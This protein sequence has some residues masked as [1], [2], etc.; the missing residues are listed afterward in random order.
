MPNEVIDHVHRMAHQEKANHSL[1]FQ[2]RNR[3]LLSDQDDEDNDESYS[4]SV[5]DEA[6]EYELLEPV[7]DGNDDHTET[8]GVDTLAELEPDMI[9]DGVPLP[10]THARLEQG[11]LGVEAPDDA[12]APPMGPDTTNPI[13]EPSLE[14]TA[15]PQVAPEVTA[16]PPLI[17]AP[18]PPG[19][20]WELCRLEINNEVPPLTHGRTRLQSQQ[21][22]LTTIGDPPIPINQMTP[23][24]QELFTQWIK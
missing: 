12:T 16:T 2:N 4:P 23:F 19:T 11:V 13:T 10:D 9:G 24:E 18:V 21:L 17:V 5:T 3:E 1:V 14:M 6:T 8:Q 20:E 7:D 15:E 22:N